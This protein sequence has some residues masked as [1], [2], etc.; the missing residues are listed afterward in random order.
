MKIFID[1]YNGKIV[2]IALNALQDETNIFVVKQQIQ[3]YQGGIYWHGICI[4][5]A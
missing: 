3:Y 4:N 1:G 5:I 2:H